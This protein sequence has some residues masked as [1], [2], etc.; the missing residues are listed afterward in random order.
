MKSF[1]ALVQGDTIRV[2][3]YARVWIE[4]SQYVACMSAKC[5]TLYA[6]VW[7]EMYNLK[8]TNLPDRVTLYARVWIE[9]AIPA[10]TAEKP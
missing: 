3:L 1:V 7:I 9:I 10:F 6:R 4:I 5:V 8:H 2:T